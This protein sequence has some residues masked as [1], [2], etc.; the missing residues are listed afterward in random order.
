MASDNIRGHP[1]RIL[2]CAIHTIRF[3]ESFMVTRFHLISGLPR[4][5]STLLSALLRQNSRFAAAMTSPVASLSAAI[6]K[7]MCGGEFA[8]FFDD[9][10]RAT[11]LR[12]VFDTYYSSIDR[13]VV[14]DTNRKWTARAALIGQL[15][16]EARIIC[17]VRDIG[18]IIDSIEHMLAKNP[19]QLSRVFDF[20]PGS[21]IYSRVEML[22]NS[23]NGLIGLPWSNLREAWFGK[24]AQRLIIVPYDELT[25]APRVILRSLYE[26]LG[27]PWF[28]HDFNNVEYDEPEYDAE[29]GMPGMHQ[30][31]KKV[32]AIARKP[33]IPPDLFV[34][35]ANTHFWNK[36][37]LNVHGVRILRA[38]D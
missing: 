27:E 6:H 8:V 24:E 11:M 19:L 33:V 17:C 37:E 31:R 14:F 34:K 26:F 18:W 9:A 38:A 1:S 23:E 20:Q 7:K 22:M 29:L 36:P 28:E 21:S 35:Y 16:P 13:P 10:R 12:G 4:S 15:Y 5:G 2:C 25:K 3:H 30:V 32:E